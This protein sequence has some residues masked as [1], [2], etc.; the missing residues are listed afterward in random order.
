MY[1]YHYFASLIYLAEVYIYFGNKQDFIKQITLLIPTEIIY[2][3]HY[4][5]YQRLIAVFMLKHC[6]GAGLFDVSR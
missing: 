5:E 6:L 3:Y 2:M 4:M 1:M